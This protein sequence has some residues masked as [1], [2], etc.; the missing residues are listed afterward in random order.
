MDDVLLSYYNRELAYVRKLGAEFADQ[1]PK[2]AGRLRL[3]K[4][5]VEDPHV[6]RLIESFAFLTA[7]I[8]HSIDDSFPELTEALMGILY[9]DF[10]APF[11]SMTIVQIRVIEKVAKSQVIVPK[12][13]VYYVNAGEF[14][15]CYYTS[16]GNNQVLPVEIKDAKFSNVPV[17]APS[18]P[19]DFYSRPATKSVYKFAV[20]PF[21]G[22]KP[23]DIT[24]DKIRFYINAQPQIAFKLY[25]YL[26]HRSVGVAIAKNS[27][28][29][30]AMFLPASCIKACNFEEEQGSNPETIAPDGRNSSAHRKIIEYFVFPNKFLFFDIEVDKDCWK[31]FADGFNIY[32]YFDQT[33]PELVQGVDDS[34]LLLGCTPAMNLY[35][36]KVNAFKGSSIGVEQK[37]ETTGHRSRF[38]D[39]HK[40]NRV[41]GQDEKGKN[42]TIMPFYGSH[43]KKNKDDPE[44]YWHLRRENS[45]HADGMVSHGTDAYLS[46]VD[47]DFKVMEPDSSWVINADVVCTNRDV[48]SKLSFGPDQP[49]IDLLY[50]GGG[51]LRFKCVVPPTSNIQP[52]L[53]DSSRWQLVT[54]LSLQSFSGADGLN[55][56]KETLQLHDLLSSRES[57]SIIDGITALK[58]S[59]A[60]TRMVSEGRAAICQG[61]KITLDFDEHYYSGNGLYLFSSVLNEF[62]AQF[63][64]INSFTQLIVNI[65]QQPD[66]TI[67]WPPRI[68]K[69]ELI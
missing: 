53:D 2:I 26:L 50:G 27:H 15:D 30:D 35:K 37:L 7:R 65:K 39:I 59:L 69:Q 46:F 14:G 1:H 40:I 55:V 66:N 22:V 13:T 36:E 32:I 34:T 6:S 64:T 19:S 5:T 62:F 44:M 48:P 33:H 56:L 3:D 20:K 54:Q 29:T 8:R 9:P 18:L 21:E 43:L 11:P 58:T 52:K 67:E 17:K 68:G 63:C 28:D 51:G 38:V 10:H 24:E 4:D 12:S 47:S 49:E 16:L 41:Y 25:E 61:T 60:T 31:K 42:I 45:Q 23:G 57:R